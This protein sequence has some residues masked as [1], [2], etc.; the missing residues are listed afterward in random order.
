MIS[1][2]YDQSINQLIYISFIIC[3]K[4]LQNINTD[5]NKLQIRETKKLI[6]RFFNGTSLA[7]LWSNIFC[8]WMSGVKVSEVTV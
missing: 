2:L 4:H 7:V 3:S 1:C 5:L 8:E 6:Y